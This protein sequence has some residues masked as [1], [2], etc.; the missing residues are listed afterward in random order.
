MKVAL[1]RYYITI[2]CNARV[3]MWFI[4][5]SLHTVNLALRGYFCIAIISSARYVPMWV[6]TCLFF[7]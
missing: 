1:L 5:C 7:V 3:Q 4:I 6:S 2:G